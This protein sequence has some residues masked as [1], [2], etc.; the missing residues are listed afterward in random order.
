[1]GMSAAESPLAARLRWLTPLRRVP[2][3]RRPLALLFLLSLSAAKSWAP[4]GQ[5]S[6]SASSAAPSHPATPP[7]RS[8]RI[9]RPARLRRRPRRQAARGQAP[10]QHRK[11]GLL[12]LGSPGRS[13][14]CA[15][16]L[17]RRTRA[18]P[19]LTIGSRSV[20][21]FDGHIPAAPVSAFGVEFRTPCEDARCAAGSRPPLQQKRA[22]EGQHD[23][24]C[25][26]SVHAL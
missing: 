23:L 17:R 25:V 16:S 15:D 5:P 10:H 14:R 8:T 26:H 18:N 11:T 19:G 1:M 13:G 24:A 2:G 7:S 4:S 9:H 21:F 3:G 12:P 20:R 6:H 22:S